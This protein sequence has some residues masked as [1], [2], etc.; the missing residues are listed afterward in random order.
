M[1]FRYGSH[2][3]IQQSLRTSRISCL[4]DGLPVASNGRKQLRGEGPQ[5]G[6]LET[7]SVSHPQQCVQASH[8]T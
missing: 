6:S 4:H 7:L 5:S 8:I 3:V 2:H 1:P